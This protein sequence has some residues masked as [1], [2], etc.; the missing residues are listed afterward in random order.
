MIC[1]LVAP[2]A[3][4]LFLYSVEF[5]ADSRRQMNIAGVARGGPTIRLVDLERF[6]LASGEKDQVHVCV[7]VH[8]STYTHV[9]VQMSRNRRMTEV[10]RKARGF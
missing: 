5:K 8:T 9:D 3:A 6:R 1:R 4:T 7:I 2:S 10:V